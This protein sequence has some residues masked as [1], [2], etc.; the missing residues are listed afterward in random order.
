[1]GRMSRDERLAQAEECLSSGMTVKDWCAANGV[2]TATMYLWLRRLREE[3][4]CALAP[5]FVELGDDRAEWDAAPVAG[6]P[7]VVRVGGAEVIVPAGAREREVSM[8]VRA[9]ASL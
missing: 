6:A 7:V 3:R 9:A 8:A 2:P 1:M 5:A 4:E